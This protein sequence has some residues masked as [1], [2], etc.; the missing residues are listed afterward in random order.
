LAQEETEDDMLSAG[1]M[2]AVLLASLLM[3]MV[4]PIA[5]SLSTGRASGMAKTIAGMFAEFPK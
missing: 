3:V 4:I 5:F 2:A 1:F